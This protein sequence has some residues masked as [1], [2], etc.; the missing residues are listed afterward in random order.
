MWVYGDITR[1]VRPAEL[2]AEVEA[3]LARGLWT[4]AL[5][6]LGQ[7]VQG[8]ADAEFAAVGCDRRSA[9]VDG[10]MTALVE[11]AGLLL[12]TASPGEQAR[13]APFVGLAGAWLEALEPIEARVP[14]GYAFYALHPALYAAAARRLPARDWR[15]IGIRSIGTSLAAV[16]AAALG[17][18]SPLTVR[19]TGHPFDRG[20]A[21][22][23]ELEAEW[24]AHPGPFA[25]VDEGPGL[26]GSSFGAVADAL[27][28]LGVA[29]ARIAFLPGHDGDL[30]P[31]AS[32]RNRARWVGALRPAAAFDEVVLPQLAAEAA[33][34]LGPAAAPLQ[35]ISGGAWRRLRTWPE[36]P[37]VNAGQ[38]RRKF[39]HRT[40][41]GAWLLKFAGLGRIGRAKLDRARALHEAGYGP[42]PAGLACGFILQRWEE[43][44][45]TPVEDAAFLDRL[46]GYLGFRAETFPAREGSGAGAPDLLEMTRANVAEALGPTAG[47][48]VLRG[49]PDLIA[50]QS[51]M[52]RVH[53]DARLHAWEWLA[54]PD[55]RLL[56][57]DG[58]DHSEGH[59][60]VGSQDIAWDVAGAEAELGLSAEQTEDLRARLSVEPEV[61]AFLRPAYLAFQLGLWTMAADAQAGWPEEAARARTQAGGYAKRLAVLLGVDPPARR[62]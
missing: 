7:L 11:V 55:G 50:L 30:G 37:P 33:A 40:A 31:Q 18:P 62:G 36:P 51:G 48:A 56:K 22:C 32:A 1:R 43:A 3:D 5:I 9:T 44:A 8:L 12:G 42:E 25:I 13:A 52:R 39:L 20:L 15:V 24:A 61:L 19:P 10:L 59:D 2:L 60:L 58:V 53:V 46:G 14:E 35:D 21:L 45:R 16:V 26:S 28:R 49:A 17:A 23:P 4:S 57:A 38:E 29:R 6:G 41:Q 34:R 27:E 54:L 47:E